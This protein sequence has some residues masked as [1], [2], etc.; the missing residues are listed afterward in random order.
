MHHR[1]VPTSKVERGITF[2]VITLFIAA[3]LVVLMLPGCKHEPRVLP[4]TGNGGGGGGG[5][6]D[7]DPNVVYY[8][9]VQSIFIT[10]CSS[11]SGSH[12]GGGCHH[13]ATDDNEWINLTSYQAMVNSSNAFDPNDPLDSDLWDEIQ[14]GDMP[15]S[16][17]TPL[18][19]EFANVIYQWLQQGATS[20][21][22]ANAGCD[23]LNVTYSGTIAP[24]VQQKCLGCHSGSNP[25]ASLNFSSHAVVS[26]AAL[27]GSIPGAIQHQAPFQPM[28]PAGGMLPQCDID[29][30]LIWIQDGAPNN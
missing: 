5:D 13:T 7:C 22:C 3:I 25:A 23:T 2:G 8:N 16:G 28:P 27:N 26:L 21:T 11:P 20:Q 29:K 12:N 17:A 10:Y 18:P 30:F 1:D 15:P 14:D 24:L 19:A 4:D 6:D 9:Q